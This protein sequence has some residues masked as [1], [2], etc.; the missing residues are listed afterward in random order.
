MSRSLKTGPTQIQLSISID[1]RPNCPEQRPRQTTRCRSHVYTSCR[2]RAQHTDARTLSSHH[3]ALTCTPAHAIIAQHVRIRVEDSWPRPAQ[4]FRATHGLDS[5]FGA[6]RWAAQHAWHVHVQPPT[7]H[8]H[9]IRQMH[10]HRRGG[11]ARAGARQG[12]VS[13][14]TWAG[15]LTGRRQ[16]ARHRPQEACSADQPHAPQPS[17]H[18]ARSPPLYCTPSGI[19]TSSKPIDR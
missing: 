4:C 8:A 7:A 16:L 19:I 3:L 6:H 5:P 1:A 17:P 14:L 9:A 15:R 18:T 11:A 13:Q 2:P 12:I 10:I